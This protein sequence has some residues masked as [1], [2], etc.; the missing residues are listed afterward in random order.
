ML[1]PLSIASV[2]GLAVAI[3]VPSVSYALNYTG[4][5]KNEPTFETLEE[6]RESGPKAVATIEGN[7]G[8]TFKSHPALDSIPKGTVFVYRSSNL[9]GGRA[10]A[11]LNTDILVFSDKHFATK[12]EAKQYIGSMGLLKFVD[13]VKGSVILV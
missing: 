2:L 6:A 13:E 4:S 12:E 10:A 3:T 5:Q 9:Y 1:K 11:R 8:R 7:A